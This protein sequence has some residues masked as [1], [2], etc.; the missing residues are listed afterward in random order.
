MQEIKVG[1]IVSGIYKTGKYIGE[2]TD[3]RPMHFLVKVKAVL[4]HPL[5]GDLHT[6]KGVEVPLFHERRAL[7]YHEQTNI[8]K[9]MVKQYEENIPEYKDSLKDAVD[10]AVHSLEKEDSEWA[11]KSLANFSVLKNDYKL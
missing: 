6:P 5:Q 7:A 3:I 1:S 8:P 4:K 2:V 9:N 11:K 10:A